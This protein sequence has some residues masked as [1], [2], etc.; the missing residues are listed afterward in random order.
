MKGYDMQQ[1]FHRF[2]DYKITVGR[3]PKE[4]VLELLSSAD[5][6]YAAGAMELIW[7]YTGGLVWF[8]KLL[9]NAA[10]RR[11][12]AANRSWVYPADVFFSLPDVVTDLNCAQF[13]EGCPSGSLEWQMIDVM[14]S[15][16]YR[17]DMYLS[18]DTICEL[19]G[20]NPHE[21][22][23]ALSSLIHFEIAERNPVNPDMVRF[24]LDIYRRYFRTTHSSYKHIPEETVV[25]EP[26]S[27]AGTAVTLTALSEVYADDEEI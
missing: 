24:C 19:L 25:F 27:N 6:N 21:V 5:V 2:G 22:E 16:A 8:V 14:Q 20:R 17:K 1:V 9:G 12:K 26:R 11:A 4:D 15:L 13:Y 23:Q 7:E 18:M 10:I 3:L